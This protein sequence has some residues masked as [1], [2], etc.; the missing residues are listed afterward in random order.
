MRAAIICLLA[1]ASPPPINAG[2]FTSGEAAWAY[3][4]DA[5]LGYFS[6]RDSLFVDID[7][8]TYNISPALIERTLEDMPAGQREKVKAIIPVH[9]YG[10]PADMDPILDLA[11]A[12]NLVVIEDACQ[13]HLAEWKGKRV[14]TLGATGCFLITK[15]VHEPWGRKVP[16]MPGTLVLFDLK[17][18]GFCA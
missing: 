13:A 4:V 11:N 8:D 7:P 2:E 14:G 18:S 17:E 12:R 15:A 6:F 10:Q 3:G 16:L 5:G 1:A 9:L